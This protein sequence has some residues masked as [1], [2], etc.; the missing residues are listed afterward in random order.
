MLASFLYSFLEA[1]KEALFELFPGLL[2]C[3]GLDSSLL[4]TDSMSYVLILT[5]KKISDKEKETE[6]KVTK[7]D[8]QLYPVSTFHVPIDLHMSSSSEP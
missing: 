3:L 5:A 1:K 2:I 6:Q 7:F 8:M 4:E